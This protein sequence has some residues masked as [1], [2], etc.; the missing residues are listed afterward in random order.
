[1]PLP[2]P[3]TWDGKRSKPDCKS[4]RRMRRPRQVRRNRPAG[5]CGAGG[6]PDDRGVECSAHAWT[7]TRSSFRVRRLGE[8]DQAV[9]N[10]P[11]AALA[12]SFDCLQVGGA[13]AEESLEGPEVLDQPVSKIGRQAV[14]LRH[15]PEPAGGDVA[16]QVHVVR[17]AGGPRDGERIQQLLGVQMLQTG[18]TEGC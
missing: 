1:M 7:R 11:G 12:D 3:L 17:E 4:A 5:G 9:T 6:T 13:G 14:D 18:E 10:H 16:F 8:P 2:G 15:L